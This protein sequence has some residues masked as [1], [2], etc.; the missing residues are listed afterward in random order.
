MKIIYNSIIPFKGFIAINLFGLLF[1]R[2]DKKKK[3]TKKVINHE[4]IH[5]KQYIEMAYIFFLIWYGIEWLIKLC[6]YGNAHK[7]YKNLS[8]EREANA[9]EANL[10]YLDTRK[11]YAW[12]KYIK[13]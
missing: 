4:T 2:S 11:H 5:T 3:I 8:F 7:A 1:V 12:F 10:Q 6:I 9:N 13:G